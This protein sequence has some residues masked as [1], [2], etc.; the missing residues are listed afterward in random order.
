MDT[1]MDR[2]RLQFTNSLRV[3]R[4]ELDKY[5]RIVES[6]GFLDKTAMH[7]FMF[8]V[9]SARASARTLAEINKAGGG[10]GWS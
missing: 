1:E 3:L 10:P 8:L 5:D 7:G 6:V 4:A 9:A 2:A